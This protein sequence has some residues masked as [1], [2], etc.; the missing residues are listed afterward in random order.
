MPKNLFVRRTRAHFHFSFRIGRR[1]ARAHQA[2]VVVIA[3]ALTI[4]Q[5]C[6]D[7]CQCSLRTEQHFSTCS[8]YV[9]WVHKSAYS[10]FFPPPG[11][12]CVLSVYV[13]CLR[14]CCATRFFRL[15][16]SSCPSLLRARFRILVRK[17][18]QCTTVDDCVCVC[19]CVL[20]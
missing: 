15:F 6:F 20:V 17:L 8:I 2:I 9:C 3:T 16:F 10:F 13:I 5:H 11:T 19:V 1:A 14:L 4:P 7:C 18:N 12:A